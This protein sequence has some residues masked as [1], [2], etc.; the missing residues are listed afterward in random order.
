M[1]IVRVGR[2]KAK[3][4]LLDDLRRIYTSEA[5]PEIR[6]AKGNIGAFLLCP[7]QSMNDC[8]AITAWESASDADE[9]AAS[10]Q[11]RTMIDKVR[12][13]FASAPELATYDG[14]GFDLTS[15]D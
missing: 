6:A 2:F 15:S 13:C 11:A 5:I 7:H 4:G 14:Y 8:L 12:H 1:T 9:Y 10:G 3:D